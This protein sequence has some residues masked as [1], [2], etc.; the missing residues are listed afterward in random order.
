[1]CSTG[2][3]S[4][5]AA[6]FFTTN[7]WMRY[8]PGALDVEMAR[9]SGAGTEWQLMRGIWSGAVVSN[10]KKTSSLCQYDPTLKERQAEEVVE[11]GQRV[12][13]VHC[14]ALHH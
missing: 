2:A 8:G 1:M 13:I 11:G 10:T 5:V 3:R 7:D 14:P 9:V 12:G 6:L 4:Q